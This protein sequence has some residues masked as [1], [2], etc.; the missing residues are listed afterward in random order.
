VVEVR[1]DV[2]YHA[3]QLGEVKGQFRLVQVVHDH[4]NHDLPTVAMEGLAPAAVV[5]QVV[6]GVK[7]ALDA[8]FVHRIPPV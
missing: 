8:N 6:C 2:V 5:S 3:L 4:A 7:V 1:K